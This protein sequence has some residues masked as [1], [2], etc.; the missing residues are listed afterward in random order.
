MDAIEQLAAFFAA[1]I[2]AYAKQNATW[3]DRTGAARQGLRAF[4]VRAATS[5]VLVLT[6]SV[7]YGLWLEILH[8]GRFAI[9][10]RTLQQHYAPLMAAVRRLVA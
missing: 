3:T 4:T 6:H 2:E 5:V 10:M 8:G 1:K 9:I 7:A